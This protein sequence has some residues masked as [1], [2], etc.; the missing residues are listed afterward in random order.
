MLTNSEFTRHAAFDPVSSL[1]HHPSQYTAAV[2]VS[3]S[4]AVCL[5]VSHYVRSL[6]LTVVNRD[7][8]QSM[9]H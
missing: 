5:T 9:T 7:H 8:R 2:A 1:A 4:A 3:S 6:S